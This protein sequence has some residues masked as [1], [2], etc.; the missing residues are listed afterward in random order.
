VVETMESAVPF[1]E[2]LQHAQSQ[3][4]ADTHELA[5][6][7]GGYVHSLRRHGCSC[8][9]AIDE[10]GSLARLISPISEAPTESR[11]EDDWRHYFALYDTLIQRTI[12]A[13]VLD[14]NEG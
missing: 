2:A 1:C 5:E 3:L 14:A 12:R 4:Y 11:W 7:L 9:E 13:Y 6:A 10:V 8:E